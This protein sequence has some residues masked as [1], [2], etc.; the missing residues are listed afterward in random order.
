MDNSP[1]LCINDS[2]P[3]CIY[4]DPH[5]RV[6]ID[7]KYNLEENLIATHRINNMVKS[8]DLLYMDM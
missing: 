5:V 7:T 3:V 2:L 4:V 1:D 6:E 8:N